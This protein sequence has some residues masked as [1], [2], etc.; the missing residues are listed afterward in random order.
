[1]RLHNEFKVSLGHLGDWKEKK[2]GWIDKSSNFLLGN[3]HNYYFADFSCF[4]VI[5]PNILRPKHE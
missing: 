5:I 2:R 3:N 1:M 4:K